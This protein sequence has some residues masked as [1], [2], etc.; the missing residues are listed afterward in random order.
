MQA[1]PALA[2]C[3]AIAMYFWTI[4]NVARARRKYGVATPAI[5]GN[6][7]FE[8]VFRTQQNTVEHLVMFV[9]CLLLFS[10]YWPTWGA[11]IG[12]V[13]VIAR[14]WYALGYYA[15]TGKKRSPGFGLSVAALAV[16]FL[17][18]LTGIAMTLAR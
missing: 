18:S 16:L 6:A 9:P 7:D 12:L 2:M 3:L 17:G 8:R 11:G 15:P 13:W 5:T 10:Q 4:V 14:V 1:L